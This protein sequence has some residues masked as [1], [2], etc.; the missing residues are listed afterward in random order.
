MASIVA[1]GIDRLHAI[2]A[3]VSEGEVL[4]TGDTLGYVK[5]WKVRCDQHFELYEDQL[6]RAH[7]EQIEG[8]TMAAGGQFLATFASDMNVRLWFVETCEY[9]GTFHE[10]NSWACNDQETWAKISPAEIDQRHFKETPRPSGEHEIVR[11]VPANT[12]ARPTIVG[13]ESRRST[14]EQ[15][16]QTFDMTEIRQVFNEFFESSIGSNIQKVKAE[17]QILHLSR[18][19]NPVVVPARS[20][21]MPLTARPPE[22]I[23]RVRGLLHGTTADAQKGQNSQSVKADHV[24]LPIKTPKQKKQ[25]LRITQA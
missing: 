24:R 5:K 25:R 1:H 23:A 7:N 13:Q 10:E 21:E 14:D 17:E 18:L 22:L 3:I 4:F 12:S 19:E 16:L 8:L 20:H 6:F 2:S 9:I 15:P 11:F